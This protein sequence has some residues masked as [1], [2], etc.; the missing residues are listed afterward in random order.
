MS[1]NPIKEEEEFLPFLD[2]LD[3]LVKAFL[4]ELLTALT[5]LRT[6]LDMSSSSSLELSAKSFKARLPPQ[7]VPLVCAVV[8]VVVSLLLKSLKKF[9][10]MELSK[11]GNRLGIID[12]REPP[13]LEPCRRWFGPDKS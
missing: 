10:S 2:F 5:L 8:L 13:S 7:E 9:D 11:V 4:M 3:I 6:L 12:R 1:S